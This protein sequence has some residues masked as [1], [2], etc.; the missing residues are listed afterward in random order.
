[1]AQHFAISSGALVFENIDICFFLS[2]FL[3]DNTGAYRTLYILT[4]TIANCNYILEINFAFLIFFLR[5]SLNIFKNIKIH[6]EIPKNITA[7]LHGKYFKNL[8]APN[9]TPRIKQV[10]TGT[11]NALI[12][13]TANSLMPQESPKP[14]HDPTT[15]MSAEAPPK[16]IIKAPR[17]SL[18]GNS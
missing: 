2:C 15:C 13:F 10:K 16:P 5:F 11:Q 1:M 6:A 9:I 18:F 12:T 8:S 4:Q 14:S 3:A 7:A 17:S